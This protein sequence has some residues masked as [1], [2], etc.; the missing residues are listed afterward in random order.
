MPYLFP[1]FFAGFR[2]EAVE[3][4]EGDQGPEARPQHLRWR[5]WRSSHEG[6]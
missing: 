1:L 4:D 5:E 3:P 2:E 6:R